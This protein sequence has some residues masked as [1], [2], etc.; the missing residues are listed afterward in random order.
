L[1]P[2]K[3]EAGLRPAMLGGERTPVWACV[4]QEKHQDGA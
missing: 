2:E 3:V 1:V 4:R